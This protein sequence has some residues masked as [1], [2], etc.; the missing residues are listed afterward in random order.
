MYPLPHIENP[1]F[2]LPTNTEFH[3]DT[4][5][6]V[7]LGAVHTWGNLPKIN[8]GFLLPD[9]GILYSIYHYCIRQDTHHSEF[10][11]LDTLPLHAIGIGLSIDLGNLLFDGIAHCLVSHHDGS[12]S[13]LVMGS[14][15]T[16]ILVFL[17]QLPHYKKELAVKPL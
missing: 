2:P 9:Y 3:F 1:E 5:L 14:L 15:I 10:T 11:P 4:I 8:T 12:G 7:L 16:K 6:S 13:P 17:F